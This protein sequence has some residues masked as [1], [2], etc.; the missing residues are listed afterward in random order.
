MELFRLE[1]FFDMPFEQ[2]VCQFWIG[3]LDVIQQGGLPPRLFQVW[4]IQKP[5]VFRASVGQR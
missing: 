1:N 5:A 4:P 2:Q 3:L